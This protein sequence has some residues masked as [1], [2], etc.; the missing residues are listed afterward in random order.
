[1]LVAQL[2]FLLDRFLG[3]ISDIGLGVTAFPCKVAADITA[4]A[5]L[6]NGIEYQLLILG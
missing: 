2:G 4:V 3:V 6:V 1:M 5:P